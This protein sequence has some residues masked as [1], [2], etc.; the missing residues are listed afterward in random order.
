MFLLYLKFL[1]YGTFNLVSSIMPGLLKDRP[2]TPKPPE[3]G[4]PTRASRAPPPEVV[5]DPNPGQPMPDI[6]V[7][8]NV[9]PYWPV[10]DGILQPVPAQG[11]LGRR[12]GLIV[13]PAH[14]E[15]QWRPVQGP[16]FSLPRVRAPNSGDGHE[17][18]RG[19]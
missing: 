12:G 6:Y 9:R 16:R 15:I 1:F 17:Q 18:P 4:V 8:R 13:V 10:V 7:R 14:Q 5:M 19:F 2:D 3:Q 11:L